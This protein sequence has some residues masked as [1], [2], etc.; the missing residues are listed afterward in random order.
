MEGLVQDVSIAIGVVETRDGFLAQSLS[1]KSFRTGLMTAF[2]LAALLLAVLGIAGVMAY[3]VSHRTREIGVR[4]AL[5]A[6]PTG[7][8]GAG[9]ARRRAVDFHRCRSR[10]HGR[11]GFR[12]RAHNARLRGRRSGVRRLPGCGFVPHRRHADRVSFAGEPSVQGRSGF[13]AFERVGLGVAGVPA[14]R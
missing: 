12:A 9:S 14:R 4:L 5:G 8:P 7:R 1:A 10:G 13:G 3:S 2:A 6:E 11:P